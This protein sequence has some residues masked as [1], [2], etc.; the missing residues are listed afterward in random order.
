MNRDN[1]IAEAKKW[2]GSRNY[3]PEYPLYKIMA[4]F[5]LSQITEREKEI[6]TKLEKIANRAPTNWHRELSNVIKMLKGEP[7]S[8]E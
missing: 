6:A 3:A 4:D 1:L 7:Y 8:H 5:A 2:Y